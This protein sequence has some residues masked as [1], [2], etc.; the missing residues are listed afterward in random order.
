M[1]HR[2]LLTCTLVLL[3]GCVTVHAQT[4]R[5]DILR[6]QGRYL[7]GA[8]WYNLNTARADRINVET[9][10]AANR[11]AQRLYRDYMADRAKRISRSKGLTDKH[12]DALFKKMAEDQRR[13]RDN[14]TPDDI[15]SG[16][17][18]N[19]IVED[20]ADPD[21][22]PSVWRTATVP[23]PPGLTL[24][25]LS[26]KIA[27]PK[28]SKLMQ[29]TVAIDRMRIAEKKWPLPF[30]RPE[31]QKPCKSYEQT[32]ETVVGK[33]LK[34]VDLQ[35]T[36]YDKL[37]AS[38]KKLKEAVEA[39]IPF[40]DDQR[41]Q[42]REY[43]GGLEAASRI[44][45]E[46]TYAE[47]LIRDVSDH[48][49][50]TV[51]ELLAFMRDYRLLFANPGTSHDASSL[52]TDLYGLLRRQKEILGVGSGPRPS[53]VFAA[54]SVWSNENSDRPVKVRVMDRKPG[55]FRA[56]FIVGADS[57]NVREIH[58]R[59]DDTTITWS[60]SDSEPARG[61]QAKT[62]GQRRPQEK[63]KAQAQGRGRTNAT[64]VGTIQGDSLTIT[65]DAP[66]GRGPLVLKKIH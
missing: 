48:Q 1:R 5:G 19:A 58:G 38:V 25:A 21:I 63:T 55:E 7:E 29:S 27:D 14:P 39:E 15:A 20:L 28:K 45:A 13:W 54:G 57:R 46:Q 65:S 52:Y 31:M 47:Q 37:Q 41:A 62:K 32:V 40:N 2:S 36:D 22:G 64:H 33:C 34:S 56:M 10:K 12:Q 35:A 66:N 24:T 50:T 49:A 11:E 26:F 51:A 30:R 23:L 44:F 3:L 60:N 9:W 43:V 18:L 42:A 17:A 8:G 16:D 59:V 4:I 6:A 61:P 53:D